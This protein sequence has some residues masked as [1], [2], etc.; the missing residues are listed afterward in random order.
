L[1]IEAA[2]GNYVEAKTI[3]AGKAERESNECLQVK[4]NYVRRIRR[5]FE[6]IYLLTILLLLA[7][8][9]MYF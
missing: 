1:T 9:I 2:S 7:D 6:L 5:P 8:T 3:S 4:D